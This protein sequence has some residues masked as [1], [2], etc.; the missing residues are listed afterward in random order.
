ML[1]HLAAGSVPPSASVCIGG[2]ALE[3][4]LPT[5]SGDPRSAD[6]GPR[7]NDCFLRSDR[8]GDHTCKYINLV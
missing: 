8:H 4:P 1:I 2:L 3:N 6:A 7:Q 5:Q